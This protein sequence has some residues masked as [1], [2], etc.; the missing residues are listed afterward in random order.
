MKS[1]TQAMDIGWGQVSVLAWGYTS[2]E[3]SGLPW[4]NTVSP[5]PGT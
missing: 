4:L 3:I 1:Q 2:V 5:T